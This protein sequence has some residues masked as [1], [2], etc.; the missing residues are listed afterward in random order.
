MPPARSRPRLGRVTRRRSARRTGCWR[1]RDT[2]PATPR[3]HLSWTHVRG[4][5]ARSSTTALVAGDDAFL[6]GDE[7]SGSRRLRGSACRSEQSGC[8]RQRDRRSP[9]SDLRGLHGWVG[10]G[11]APERCGRRCGMSTR[12]RAGTRSRQSRL[13]IN[14]PRARADRSGRSRSGANNSRTDGCRTEGICFSAMAWLCYRADSGDIPARCTTRCRRNSSSAR[15][16]S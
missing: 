5:P 16:T 7:S 3:W 10:R 11:H 15:W 12:P 6:P 9:P 8:H 2:G 4:P 1:W 13:C 14:D